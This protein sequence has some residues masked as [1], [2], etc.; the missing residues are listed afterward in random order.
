MTEVRQT[1]LPGVGVRYEFETEEG[2]LVGVICH[3]GGRRELVVYDRDDPDSARSVVELSAD[4]ARTVTEL[5]GAS[6]VA[7]VVNEVQ[8]QV[9]G[10]ALEWLDIEE[11]SPLAGHSIGEGGIRKRTG[12]S[13]VAVVRGNSSEPAPGPDYELAA[14]DVVVAVG[15]PDALDRLRALVRS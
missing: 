2:S 6:Q 13:I 8:Q 9:E 7:E 3:H 1:K 4:D 5:L 14:G 11:W 12:A 15:T 10:M